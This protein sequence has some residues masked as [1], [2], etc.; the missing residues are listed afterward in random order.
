MTKGIMLTVLFAAILILGGCSEEG[1]GG[2]ASITGNVKHHD[3]PIP[4]ATVY[5]KY[6]A[7]EFPGHDPAI[8]DDETQASSTDGQYSIEGLEKGAYYLYSAGYDAQIFDSVFGGI[9]VMIKAGEAFETDIPVT[10]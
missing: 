1:P 4:N 9:H 6:G 10:E 7:T 2:K 8:Y 5:I 3:E